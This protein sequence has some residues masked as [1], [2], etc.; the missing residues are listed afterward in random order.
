MKWVI[1]AEVTGYQYEVGDIKIAEVT[2]YPYEVGDISW[3]NW[4]S[5]WSGWY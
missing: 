2:G 1:L 4:L 3:G 5:V